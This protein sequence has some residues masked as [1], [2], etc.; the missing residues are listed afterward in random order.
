MGGTRTLLQDEIIRVAAV[1]F[2]ELGYR[3][4]TLDT[5]AAKV[6]ISKVTLY[7][8]AG[9]KEELLC[10]VFE[11]TIQSFRS[12]LREIVE[13]PVPADDKLRR[14]IQH[15]VKLLSTH[16]PFLTVFFSEEGNLPPHM[17]KRAAR[18]KREYDRAIE[19]VVRE[20]IAEGRFRDLPPTLLV[21][22]LLGMCNWLYKWYRP[23]GRLSPE[24]IAAIFI[25]LLEH[26]YLRHPAGTPSDDV[27]AVLRRIETRLRRLE[28]R[29]PLAGPAGPAPRLRPRRQRPA[30]IRARPA[31]SD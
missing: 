14:I 28:R 18:E 6:G 4:T 11:R 5:I 22:S 3:A 13:Q 26:G 2:G 27:A 30:A 1:C 23:E 21:F 31:S 24:E 7:K 12:G 8:H 16:L 15:Q 17:A 10:R 29:L 25:D 9:S 19:R 20:G